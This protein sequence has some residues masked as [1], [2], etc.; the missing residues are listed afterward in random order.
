MTWSSVV[1]ASPELVKEEDRMA[2]LVDSDSL[3]AAVGLVGD[4]ALQWERVRL[5]S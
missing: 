3:K 2:V 1:D 4:F 5:D